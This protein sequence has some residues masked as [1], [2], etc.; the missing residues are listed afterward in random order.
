[1]FNVL[2][3]V[4]LWLILVT[5]GLYTLSTAINW[6]VLG[7]VQ[8]W[9]YARLGWHAQ[10]PSQKVFTALVLPATLIVPAIATL[11]VLHY[12]TNALYFRF[13]LTETERYDRILRHRV[14][15]ANRL[16]RA[17]FTAE[18]MAIRKSIHK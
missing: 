4:G 1:M 5:V 2:N 3:T 15:L 16:Q 9:H 18:A 17:G 10:S 11:L 14:A 8:A 12:I 13:C 7:S 6:M